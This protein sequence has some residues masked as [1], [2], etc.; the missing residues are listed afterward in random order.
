MKGRP[1]GAIVKNYRVLP[2][3]QYAGRE[4]EGRVLEFFHLLLSSLL[5][6]LPMA[7]YIW[8]QLARIRSPGVEVSV[9]QP[10]EMQISQRG[11]ENG[12]EGEERQR[13]EQAQDK[14]TL[15]PGSLTMT[16][17]WVAW[18]LRDRESSNITTAEPGLGS[19]VDHSLLLNQSHLG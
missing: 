19:D 18:A 17:G 6:T 12:S 11:V 8:N 10:L 3:M 16:Y 5:L 15:P 7:E 9:C 2:K 14:R 4:G 1:P 13:E